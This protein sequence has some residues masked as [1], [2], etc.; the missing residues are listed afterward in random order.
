MPADRERRLGLRWKCCCCRRRLPALPSS[1][2]LS[3]LLGQCPPPPTYSSVRLEPSKQGKGDHSPPSLL[4][5]PTA[6][7]PF[8]PPVSIPSLAS[9]VPSGKART[10]PSPLAPPTSP[11]PQ[12]PSGQGR[13]P[14][15]HQHPRPP[16]LSAF[17]PGAARLSFTHSTRQ[18]RLYKRGEGAFFG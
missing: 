4:L 17:S 16:P 14:S 3:P 1:G 18:R 10:P 8:A 11:P 9:M 5:S 7:P 2:R 13:P 12:L 6:F 15:S